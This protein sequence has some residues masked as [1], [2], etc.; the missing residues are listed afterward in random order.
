MNIL[1]LTHAYPDLKIKWR[2]VFVQEQVKALSLNQRVIVVYFKVDYSN[3]APF[4]D[5][6]FFKISNRKN[7]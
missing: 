7:N 3:F 2:G 5:Y 6:S 1:I 4:S